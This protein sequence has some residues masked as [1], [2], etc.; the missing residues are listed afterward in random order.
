MDVVYIYIS[1][2]THVRMYMYVRLDVYVR[3]ISKK[4]FQCELCDHQPGRG[5][6]TPVGW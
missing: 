3:V 4:D 5:G 1:I 6:Y 2:Y